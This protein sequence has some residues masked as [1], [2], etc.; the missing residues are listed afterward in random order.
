MTGTSTASVKISLSARIDVDGR[1]LIGRNMSKDA[2]NAGG[3]TTLTGNES[4]EFG[5]VLADVI[6]CPLTI[7]NAARMVE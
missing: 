6:V 2:A 1:I 4:E 7:G 3:S 5:C